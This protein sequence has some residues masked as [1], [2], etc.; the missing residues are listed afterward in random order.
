L[1]PM[2]ALEIVLSI[3]QALE[4]VHQQGIVHRDVKPGNIFLFSRDDGGI[5]AKLA[6]FS[7][8]YIPK[9]PEDDTLTKEGFFMGTLRYAPPEQIKGISN[10]PR[11]DL[12]SLTIVFYEMLSGES[13]ADSLKDPNRLFARVSEEIPEAFF[14]EKGIPTRLVEVLQKGLRRNLKDRYQSAAE[15]REV[16][17]EIK[18]QVDSSIEQHVHKGEECLKSGEWQTAQTEFERGQM[19]M[20]WYG[21]PSVTP[22]HTRKL[23]NRLRMGQLYADGM[24]CWKKKQWQEAVE[25]LL[26]MCELSASYEKEYGTIASD[27]WDLL[28]SSAQ[29]YSKRKDLTARDG[30]LQNV[31]AVLAY[32]FDKLGDQKF[33]KLQP[34]QAIRFWRKSLSAHSRAKGHTDDRT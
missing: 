14:T 4:A 31:Y 25:T 24:T 1:S 20:I 11:S 16:L 19:L 15:M 28:F 10:D 26:L 3:C 30:S 6:D 29:E 12:Y 34:I 22:E 2:A 7:I 18:S 23:A 33:F 9:R 21:E 27:F 13:P 5:V 32:S 8:A 17:V